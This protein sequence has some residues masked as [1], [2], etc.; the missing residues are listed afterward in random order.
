MRNGSTRFFRLGSISLKP[1][2]G[3]LCAV[4]LI[5]SVW[6]LVRKDLLLEWREKNALSAIV[7]YVLSTAFVIYEIFIS[8]EAAVWLALYWVITLFASVNAAA[9]SFI[10]EQGNTRLYYY[11]LVSP[12]AMLISK[13]LFNSLLMLVLALLS[14]LVFALLLGFPVQ[15][16]GLWFIVSLTGA[17]GLAL[18]FTMI[19]AIAAKAK[20]SG[21]LMTILGLPVIIPQVLLLVKLSKVVLLNVSFIFI[22]SDFIGLVAIDVV[23][24]AVSLVFFPFLWKD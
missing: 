6:F 24:V 18:T 1:N 12:Q 17:V 2:I 22:R 14:T 16:T 7:L 11:Q 15:S 9:K 4:K 19:S 8:T 20:N 5:Q 13:M 21:V 23:V 10:Q 3:H